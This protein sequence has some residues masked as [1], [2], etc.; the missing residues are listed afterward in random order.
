MSGPA[1]DA[2]SEDSDESDEE[3]DVD[4]QDQSVHRKQVHDDEDPY[5]ET[6][7][8]EQFRLTPPASTIRVRPTGL[9]VFA[10]PKTSI[11]TRK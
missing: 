2:G 5:E 6:V 8:E 10:S 3:E 7:E 9:D 1:G 11:P 4:L